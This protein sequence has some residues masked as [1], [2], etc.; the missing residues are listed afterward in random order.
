MDRP[1]KT[2]NAKSTDKSP[3]PKFS[4]FEDAM[5]DTVRSLNRSETRRKEVACK[6]S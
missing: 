3:A 1:R 2:P 5:L 4:M 6:D